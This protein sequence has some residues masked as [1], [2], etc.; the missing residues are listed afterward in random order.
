MGVTW[1]GLDEHARALAELPTLVQ[2][3]GD[4]IVSDQ[5]RAA[6]AEIRAAYPVRTGHLR[7]SLTLQETTRHGAT[8]VTVINT[9][10]YALAF[11]YGHRTTQAGQPARAAGKVFV[12][13]ML[14][15]RRRAW[16]ALTQLTRALSLT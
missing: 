12:P 3:K 16:Q 6:Y 13:R 8:V 1:R 10:R 14:R 15:A 11:E 4:A 5:M 9:A 7:A 2:A